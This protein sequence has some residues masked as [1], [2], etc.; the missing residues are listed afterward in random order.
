MTAKRSVLFIVDWYEP[1]THRAVC[2]YARQNNWDLFTVGVRSFYLPSWWK[3]D[4]V[5]SLCSGSPSG[6]SQFISG[7]GRRTPVVDM[8]NRYPKLRAVRVLPNEHRIGELAAEHFLERGFRHFAFIHNLDLWQEVG[9]Q[10][11]YQERLGK[12]GMEVTPIQWRSKDGDHDFAQAEIADLVALTKPLALFVMHDEVADRLLRRMLEEGINVP[13][14]V[15]LVSVNNDEFIC[16]YAPVPLSSVDPDWYAVGW[17]A[18]ETLQG[19]MAGGRAPGAPVQVP[20]RGM[21]CRASSDVF[22]TLDPITAK[23]LRYI[24]N[25]SHLALKASDVVAYVGVSHGTLL[26]RFR[27]HRRC[28]LNQ[29]IIR[30]RLG[31]IKELLA[32][33]SFSGVEIARRLNFGRPKAL[34]DFFRKHAG[35]SFGDYRRD[36]KKLKS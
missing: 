14:D 36:L 4:G 22:T 25:N 6:L 32:T 5:I 3:G 30:F 2:E 10:T 12:A 28:S 29:Q 16:D 8:A 11:G 31:R 24:H 23:A 1:N 35:I 26:Q 18:A 7:Q 17:A 19:L 15:A 9:R 34:Y 13:G 27:E 20:P 33:Q 21:V